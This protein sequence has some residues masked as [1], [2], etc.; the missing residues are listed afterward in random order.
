MNGQES[1]FEGVTRYPQQTPT[2][3]A[4]LGPLIAGAVMGSVGLWFFAVLVPKFL[5]QDGVALDGPTGAVVV[6]LSVSCLGLLLWML[7]RLARD[8]FLQKGW[9]CYLVNRRS[10]A[11]CVPGQPVV[12]V[13]RRDCIGCYPRRHQLVL[14]DGHTANLKLLKGLGSVWPPL[15]ER[16]WP[17]VWAAEQTTFVQDHIHARLR[18]DVLAAG[19]LW[20][21]LCVFWVELSRRFGLAPETEGDSLRSLMIGASVAA[22]VVVMGV[23][24]YRWWRGR[25]MVVLGE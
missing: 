6:L 5:Q 2:L 11:I 14:R 12:Y 1:E 9:V 17:E 7:V 8:A 4:V 21:F 15:C 20:V 22:C 16:W 25:W 13:K 19:V 23:V 24:L 18:V 3:G 10:L